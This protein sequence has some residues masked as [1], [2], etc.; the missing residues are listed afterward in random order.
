MGTD[1][2]RAT[3]ALLRRPH[4][5]TPTANFVRVCVL[6]LVLVP[7]LVL[8]LGAGC[9]CWCLCSMQN[10][11]LGIRQPNVAGSICAQVRLGERSVCVPSAHRRSC[12][13]EIFQHTTEHLTPT[14]CVCRA[15]KSAGTP[16]LNSRVGGVGGMAGDA[17]VL[18]L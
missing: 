7:V 13:H 5:R 10:M 14:W 1:C 6:V 2:M 11:A 3:A 16:E 17:L 4:T 15:A 9:C 12:S 18:A 8:V